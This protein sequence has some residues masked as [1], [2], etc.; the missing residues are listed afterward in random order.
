MA[1]SLGNAY[2]RL[3]RQADAV[4]QYL[5]ASEAG[6]D[7]PPGKQALQGLRN[8]APVLEQMAALERLGQEIDDPELRGL[9]RD[10]LAEIAGKYEDI[11]NGSEYLRQCS[12]CDHEDEIR[13]RQEKLAQNLYGEVVL[14]QGL[15]DHVKALERIQKILTHASDTTAAELLRE[16]AVLDT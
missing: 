5:R 12:A 6:P 8:L 11:A 4:E 13:E 10:R 2:S 14:Y 7:S 3:R 9:A 16:R 1:L 15:G